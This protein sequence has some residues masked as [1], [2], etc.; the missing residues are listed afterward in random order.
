MIENKP[1]A[2]HLSDWNI[3]PMSCCALVAGRRLKAT[4]WGVHEWGE[5]LIAWAAERLAR[6]AGL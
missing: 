1:S 5:G 2:L 6:K 4:G 3:A